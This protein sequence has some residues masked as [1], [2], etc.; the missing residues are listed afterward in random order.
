MKYTVAVRTLCEFTA[1]TGDLDMRFTPAP[2]GLE[3]I[4]GHAAVRARR[5]AAYLAEVAVSGEY[6]GLIVRGRADGYDPALKRIEEIKT[7]RGELDALPANQRALHRAQARVY[8]HLLCQQLSLSEI[9]VAI[10]YFDIVRRKETA[11]AEIAK[12]AVLEAEFNALCEQFMQWATQETEHRNQ[13]DQALL[14]LR[15]PLPDFRKGQ[16]PLAES[17]YKA[18]RQGRRL[19]AQA[20]TGIG[21]TIGTLFPLLKACPTARLD[22]VFFVTAKTSGRQVALDAMDQLRADAERPFIR[23]LELTARVK[24]CEYPDRACHPESCPLAR[25]FYDRLPAAREAAVHAATLNKSQLRVTAL[26]H[27]VCPYW[28][29]QDLARW[30]DVIVGDYSH[31]FGVSALLHALSVQNQ[32]RTGLLVDEAHNLLGR[33]RE[34]YTARLDQASVSRAQKTAPPALKK[35]LAALARGVRDVARAQ[36]EEYQVHPTI[37]ARLLT[38][39]LRS[40]EAIMAHMMA[41]PSETNMAV[42]ELY[43]DIMHFLRMSDAFDTHSLFDVHVSVNAPASTVGLCIRN[44]IPGPFLQSRFAASHTVSLFSATL[45]PWDFYRDTLGLPDDTAFIDVESPFNASQLDVRV[46]RRI[47]TRRQHRARSLIP[48]ADLMA[49]QHHNRPGNYLSF[50]SSFDY[51]DQAFDA[52]ARRHPDIPAW[53]QERNMS[54]SGKESFLARFSADGKGIGFAVLGGVFAEGV[55]LPGQR[56]IGAFISTLGLPQFNAINEEFRSRMGLAFGRERAYDYTYFYPGM[57]NVVQAAGRVIRRPDDR[58]VVYLIDDRFGQ[59]K[60]RRLMP[61]WWELRP[62][63]FENS[64]PQSPQLDAGTRPRDQGY[65][66]LRDN[67]LA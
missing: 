65:D 12:A 49:N 32:W 58:G 66:P 17:V 22:K 44:V 37:P 41:N 52:F 56:L 19:L 39:L 33:A 4:E 5:S 9:E 29:S 1:K 51:M 31:Y 50:F 20:P 40:G 59:A 14:A 15:F 11:I 35:T 8:G 24:A 7:F 18:A 27:D 55:D 47:S 54:E 13:R 57:R 28:L 36:T 48:I 10:V 67:A 6:R 64:R 38:A 60:A 3:G 25:G 26:Q 46:I 43:F 30:C 21:K 63:L 42:Q 2:T 53:R 45:A 16:R 62:E 61:A 23:V 34:M